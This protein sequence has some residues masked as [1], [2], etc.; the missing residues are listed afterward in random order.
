LNKYFTKWQLCP[1]P[2]KTEVCCFH[3][4]NNQKNRKLKVVF[5]ETTIKHNYSP[6]YLGVTLDSSLTFKL[7]I[8]NLRQKLKTRNNIIHKLAGT[9]WGANAHTLRVTGL[10]LV[11]STGEY[12][13]PVWKNGAHVNK[14]DAQLN[15]TL[16]IITGT[17]KSTATPWLHV[18]AHII[19]YDIRRKYVTKRICIKFQNSPNIYSITQDLLD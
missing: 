10:A 1:N 3:L 16:R 17:L 13:C 5:N 2:Q 15:T 18:L 12:C 7:H 14:I 11:Y 9:S 19:P 8:E 4:V 6:T